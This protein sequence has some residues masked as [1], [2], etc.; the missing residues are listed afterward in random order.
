MNIELSPRI[1]D[2]V[3]VPNKFLGSET[4]GGALGT[5]VGGCGETRGGGLVGVTDENG[6]PLNLVLLPTSEAKKVWASPEPEKHASSDRGATN[7]FQ[8][9][10][11]L[12]QNGLL[13][14]AKAHF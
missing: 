9:G 6:V 2:V 14:E 11:L 1:L 7:E 8:Q 12:L 10:V 4:P 13:A 3:E 5:G